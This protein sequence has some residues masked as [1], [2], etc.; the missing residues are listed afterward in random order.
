[1]QQGK[2]RILV[3][4]S[5]G[6]PT[7]SEAVREAFE[8]MFPKCDI[9]VEYCSVKSGVP[10]Q[11]RSRRQTYRG[12]NNRLK[13]IKEKYPE[14]DYFVSVEAG[15][16]RTF[17]THFVNVQACIIEKA[18]GEKA[19]SHSSGYEVPKQW[20][21]KAFKSGMAAVFAERFGSDAGGTRP[22]TKGNYSRV[23]LIT[24]AVIM[25]LANFEW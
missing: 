10:E 2:K 13:E 9:Q 20:L 7:K 18:D 19:Y 17:G 5:S 6:N 8:T 21:L 11:P 3:A 4:V 14:A 24:E 23:S 25:A 15:L 16:M 12:A 22:L 1:M